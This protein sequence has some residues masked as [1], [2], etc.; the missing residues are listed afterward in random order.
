MNYVIHV[1]QGIEYMILLEWIFVLKL[2]MIVLLILLL[3]HI[4]VIVV[5]Q[6][7]D[8]IYNQ[9][10]MIYVLRRYLVVRPTQQRIIM[11]VIHVI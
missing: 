7:L 3:I 2:S 9:V 11:Y 5:I 4:N 8:N 6:D 1:I 10:I